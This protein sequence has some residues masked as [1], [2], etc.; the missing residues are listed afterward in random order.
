MSLL[1]T[2]SSNNFVASSIIYC[3][4]RN[5]LELPSTIAW[6]P[7]ITVAC[8]FVDIAVVPA[9][10]DAAVVLGVAGSKVVP[11]DADAAVVLGVARSEV[12]PA[13]ADAAVVLEVAGSEVDPADADA[14]VV[15]EVDV[16][17]DGFMR[18]AGNVTVETGRLR[19]PLL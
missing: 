8:D 5:K 10:T 4:W 6:F 1:T 13:D 16:A 12:D 14:A 15:L 11:V 3:L 17:E 9:D 7:S 18:D 19:L 2:C